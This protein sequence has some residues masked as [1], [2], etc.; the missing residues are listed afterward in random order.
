MLVNNSKLYVKDYN[1]GE[2]I[3]LK[4]SWITGDQLRPTF[5][6]REQ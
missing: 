3:K 4:Y 2:F 1:V 6:S 5:T